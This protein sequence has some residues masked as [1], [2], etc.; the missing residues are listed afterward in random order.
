MG[1]SAYFGESKSEQSDYRKDQ[2]NDLVY[3]AEQGESISGNTFL[4]AHLAQG[5]EEFAFAGYVYLPEDTES[6]GRIPTLHEHFVQMQDYSALPIWRPKVMVNNKYS[7]LTD[8]EYEML[9][10]LYRS[11][12]IP[13]KLP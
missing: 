13:K 8:E 6:N 11:V 4:K 10:D 2:F 12:M 3:A 9:L 1:R 5:I 7:D